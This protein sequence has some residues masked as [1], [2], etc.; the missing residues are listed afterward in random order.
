VKPADPAPVYSRLM[1]SMRH[2]HLL[3]SLC[4]VVPLVGCAE[5]PAKELSQAQ[6]A[7]DAARAAGAAEYAAEEFTAANDTLA[8]A[9]QAVTE[10]DYRAALSH[11]L[12][13]SAR[14]QAA[15]KSAVEGRV[16]ARLAAEQTIAEVTAAIAHVQT[17]LVTPEARRVPAPTRRRAQQ[18]VAAAEAAV[19]AARAAVETGE[20]SA[21]AGLPAHT[22]ALTDVARTLD[23]PPPPAR[24]RRR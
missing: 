12:V 6:G 19:A 14:A 4:L 17:R 1:P 9:H 16:K 20:L 10:R 7:I 15:A 8:R 18:A 3:L 13:S 5:P 23:P 21:T 2:A 22:T 24:T 11:A